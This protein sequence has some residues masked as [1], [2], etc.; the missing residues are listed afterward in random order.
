VIVEL[1]NELGEA[2]IQQGLP[3]YVVVVLR[4]EALPFPADD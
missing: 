3:R 1:L 2:E 4:Q